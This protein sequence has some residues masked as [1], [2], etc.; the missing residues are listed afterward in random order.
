MLPDIKM[1][2][3]TKVYICDRI[4]KKESYTCNFKYLEIQF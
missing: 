4:C 3:K 1:P 2:A